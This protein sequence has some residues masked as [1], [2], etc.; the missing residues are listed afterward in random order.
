MGELAGNSK[1]EMIKIMMIVLILMMMV[2][3]LKV[4]VNDVGKKQDCNV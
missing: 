1:V 3:I 4:A 2:L